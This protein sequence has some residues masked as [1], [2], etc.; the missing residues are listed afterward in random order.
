MKN[1]LPKTGVQVARG[2]VTIFLANALL[3]PTGFI[4][5]IFLAH[6]L[7]PVDYGFFAL[8]SSLVLWI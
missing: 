2:A 5:A 6:K 7:G 3:L 1:T 4:T 8:V